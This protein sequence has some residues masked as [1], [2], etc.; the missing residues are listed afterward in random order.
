M[1]IISKDFLSGV[2]RTIHKTGFK[3]GRKSP[4]ILFVAGVVG[5][6]T[7]T[8]MACKATLKVNETLE[9]PREDIKKINEA[10]E[11]GITQAGEEYTEKDA[12]SDLRK[13]YI[14]SGVKL[15][16]LYAPSAIVMGLSIAAFGKSHKIMVQR[17]MALTAVAKS[18]E[19]AYT[20]YRS[21][22][23]DRFGEELD[24]EIR[25]N[26]K[27][28]EVEEKVKN[29]DGTEETKKKH[30]E[31]NEHPNDHSFFFDEA[32]TGYTKDPRTNY[33]TLCNAQ[34]FLSRRVFERGFLS[35]NDVREYFG[36]PGIDIGQVG[37]WIY[38][39]NKP[40]EEQV[41]FGMHRKRKD[42]KAEERR[43]AFIN[44]DERN[45]LLDF[46]SEPY[47]LDRI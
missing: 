22:V 29:E 2:S 11:T 12:N 42:P 33:L 46:N 18:W 6:V 43:L 7:G 31:V 21:R 47:I 45:Y 34:T 35:V 15:V 30:V 10:T 44:G 13:V 16:K 14:Q 5:V 9:Q 37:G 32:C 26:T 40:A 8:V 41:D 24:R 28:I 38:D 20:E 4:E 27:V 23:I 3:I 39:P 17:C 19:K 36:L 25:C 1:S